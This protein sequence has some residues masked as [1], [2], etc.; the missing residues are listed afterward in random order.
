MAQAFEASNAAG[1]LTMPSMCVWYD[2]K[3]NLTVSGKLRDASWAFIE[4]GGSPFVR[5]VASDVWGQAIESIGR[6]MGDGND[7]LLASLRQSD[8]RILFKVA[9][10]LGLHIVHVRFDSKLQMLVCSVC[11]SAS[12]EHVLCA[13]SVFQHL[14]HAF[15]RRTRGGRLGP[16]L[17]SAIAGLDCAWAAAAGG[18]PPPVHRPQGTS[19]SLSLSGM[20]GGWCVCFAP[21]TLSLSLFALLFIPFHPLTVPFHFLPIPFPPFVYPLSTFIYPCSPCI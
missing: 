21:F 18:G 5:A 6:L 10:L 11:P 15:N 12:C 9:N 20:P 19:S 17:P 8:A 7:D 2:S 16:A 13:I 1:A 14:E 4:A 3:V